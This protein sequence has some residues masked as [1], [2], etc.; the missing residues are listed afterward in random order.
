[1]NDT[2]ERIIGASYD[3]GY[4]NCYS[5]RTDTIVCIYRVAA[6]YD[7]AGRESSWM[8]ERYSRTSGHLIRL[9]QHKTNRGAK[10]AATKWMR[11]GWWTS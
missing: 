3:D 4:A 5:H 2:Q 10:V 9:T 11:N 1:M 6:V 7:T 8:C